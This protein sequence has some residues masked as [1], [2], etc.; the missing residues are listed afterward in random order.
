MKRPPNL[1][2]RVGGD[3]V[4]TKGWFQA[5][6]WLLARRFTQ[7]SILALFLI[8]PW[9]GIWIIKGNLNASMTL[10]VLPLTDPYVLLQSLFAGHQPEINGLVGA[11][12]IVVFY[13]LVGGR[14]YCSWVCPVNII[15]DAAH[16]LRERL[17]ISLE[18]SL[19]NPKRVLPFN[20]LNLYWLLTLRF[21]RDLAIVY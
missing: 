2:G 12:I 3:A 4:K 16:W 6:K 9:Y 15:S 1:K 11:L 7:L 5:N 10:D 20:N 8:G 19:T 13:L 14:V 17:G 21:Q 18:P